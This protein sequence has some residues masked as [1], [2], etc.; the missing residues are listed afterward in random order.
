MKSN[1]EYPV[2][3]LQHGG[4]ENETVWGYCGRVA[5]I[6]DNLIAERKAEP[7][8]IVMNNGMLR[9]S[10]NPSTVIDDALER[11]LTESCI[12]YIEKSYRVKTDKW[13]K[14]IAGLSMG[15]M[16]TCDIAFRHPELFGN[17]GS[18]NAS[19]THDRESFNTTYERP[20]PTVMKDP[21][22]FAK[23]YRIFFRSTMSAEDH[24][25]WFLADDKIC[26]DA[27]I[28]KLP[29]YHRIVYPKRTTKW[30]GWRMGLRDFA[31]LLFR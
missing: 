2:L 30:N 6:L 28:D 29:G 10:D 25:D 16:Q 15:C 27:G 1:K 9:Y 3:Y 24:F 18:L 11:I 12:P 26:A 8:M 22:K 19:M 5:Y 13:N 7:F 23:N 14:A 17:L 20:W 4:G 21:G 31:Q